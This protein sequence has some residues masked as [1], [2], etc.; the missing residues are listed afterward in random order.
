MAD[1]NFEY[2]LLLGYEGITDE[3]VNGDPGGETCCGIDRESHP[4]WNGWPRVELLKTLAGFPASVATD[5]ILQ[6]LVKNFYDALWENLKLSSLNHQALADCIYN[7]CINQGPRTIAWFQFCLNAMNQSGQPDLAED[8]QIGENTI[9]KANE[10][11]QIGMGGELLTHLEADRHAA[12]LVTAHNRP[13]SRKFL[14]GW[15]VR[16]LT[17]G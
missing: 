16:L 3:K 12:Y 7:G 8:G 15:V 10:I 4:D 5:A 2:P 17:G 11:V 9:A 1:F 13:T 14:H 6:Q